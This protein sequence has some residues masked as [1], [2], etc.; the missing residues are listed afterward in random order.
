MCKLETLLGL[1]LR[2]GQR[3]SRCEKICIQIVAAICP[4]R[5]VADSIRDIE[6]AA[7][8]ITTRPNVPRPWHNET[9]ECH[10]GSSPIT[11]QTVLF[12][13]RIP[14]LAELETTLIIIEV[15]SSDHAKEHISKARSVAVAVLETEIHHPAD[16]E[17]KQITVGKQGRRH[18]LGQNI[19]G[20]EGQRVAHQRQINELLNRA[21]SEQ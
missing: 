13:Q 16:Y 15:G 7:Y 12:D 10:V 20:C 17:R 6:G 4:E 11:M 2:F 1:T 5:E 3:I 14:E 8:Q 19:L 21:A 9:S 18:D